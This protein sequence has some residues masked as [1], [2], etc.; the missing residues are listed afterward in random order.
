MPE[1]I[2]GNGE[3]RAGRLIGHDLPVIDSRVT[4]RLWQVGELLGSLL[5][6]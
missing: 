3:N 5:H 2:S 1:R 6:C 4:G